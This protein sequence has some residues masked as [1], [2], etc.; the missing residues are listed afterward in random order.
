MIAPD[1]VLG[2]ADATGNS[3]VVRV[4]LDEKEIV[5]LRNELHVFNTTHEYPLI[6]SV[7]LKTFASSTRRKNLNKH[8]TGTWNRYLLSLVASQV[9]KVPVQRIQARPSH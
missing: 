1:V 2:T 4:T 7:I 8:R 6:A 3:N 5:S 9:A